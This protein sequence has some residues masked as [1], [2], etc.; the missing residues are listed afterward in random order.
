MLIATVTGAKAQDV[1]VPTVTIRQSEVSTSPIASH[2]RFTFWVSAQDDTALKYY[3]SAGGPLE[4]RARVS[5]NAAATIAQGGYRPW[6]AWPADFSTPIYLDVNC[7]YFYFEVRAVDAAGNYSTIASK[8]FVAPFPLAKAPVVPAFRQAAKTTEGGVTVQS[9]IADVDLDQDGTADIIEGDKATGIVSLR[10]NPA[11]DGVTLKTSTLSVSAGSL[12]AVAAGKLRSASNLPDVVISRSGSLVIYKNLGVN[13]TGDLE[14]SFSD[15][16]ELSTHYLS[17]ILVTDVTGDGVADIV[18][19]GSE[20]GENNY[21]VAVFANH[22][23]G[24]FADPHTYPVEAFIKSLAVGDMD[25]DGRPDLVVGEED[26]GVQVEVL[27][28]SADGTFS[29]GGL[30]Y[31]SYYG[32]RLGNVEVGD[33]NGDGVADIVFSSY[34][35]V[36]EGSNRYLLMAAECLFNNGHGTFESSLY[37]DADN[38]LAP[39]GYDPQT[40]RVTVAV[41]DTNFDGTKD[42]V[43]ASNVKTTGKVLHLKTIKDS[44]GTLL[45][46]VLASTAIF[47]NLAKPG[48]M[49]VGDLDNN[50][51][52]DLVFANESAVNPLNVMLNFTAGGLTAATKFTVAVTGD[53]NLLNGAVSGWDWVFSAVLTADLPNLSLKLQSKTETGA[54]TDV[55]GAVFVRQG[56]NGWKLVLTDMPVGLRSFRVVASATGFPDQITA[57]SPLVNVLP[58]AYSVD[59][60]IAD[61]TAV[62]AGKATVGPFNSTRMKNVEQGKTGIVAIK[63]TNLG[64]AEKIRFL[65]PRSNGSNKF[66]VQYATDPDFINNIS[67][68]ASLGVYE[69]AVLPKGGTATIYAKARAGSAT[70]SNELGAFTVLATSANDGV[71]TDSAT[72]TIKALLAKNV[73]F[74]TNNNDTGDGSLRA[75]LSNALLNPPKTGRP[76]PQVRFELAVADSNRP[77]IDVLSPLPPITSDSTFI[78]GNSEKEFAAFLIQTLPSA[79][80]GLRGKA[81]TQMRAAQAVTVEDGLQIYTSNTLIQGLWFGEF[82]RCIVISN[83]PQVTTLAKKNQVRGC[84]FA[85]FDNSG[86][87]LTNY[88]ASNIIGGTDVA[89][90]NVFQ[91]FTHTNVPFG[92]QGVLVSGTGCI[93]NRIEGNIIGTNSD[94]TDVNPTG[95][96]G[97][98]VAGILI[99]A[100]AQNTLVRK[101]VLSGNVGV[102]M[103]ASGLRIQGATTTGTKIQGN[104]IGVSIDGNTAIPNGAWG[105]AVD[106]PS[107]VVGGTSAGDANLISGNVRG[108]FITADYCTVQGNLIGTNSTGLLAIANDIGV[109]INEGVKKTVI[110]GAT[111]SA[112]NVISGNSYNAVRVSGQTGPVTTSE[113]SI[114]GNY[115]GLGSDGLT[116]VPNGSSGHPAIEILGAQKTTVTGNTIAYNSRDAVNISQATAVKNVVRQNWTYSNGGLG[117]NLV[118]AYDAPSGRTGN[119]AGDSDTGPNNLQ[120]APVLTSASVVK[121]GTLYYTD[122]RGTLNSNAGVGTVKNRYM[123]DFYTSDVAD[124]SGSG[125]GAVYLGSAEVVA[126]LP[127]NSTIFV[128]F[129]GDLTGKIITVTASRESSSSKP[130]PEE[131]SEFSNGVLS[132]KL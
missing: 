103:Y 6:Q 117:I 114:L 79:A 4:F 95:I 92:A 97:M 46:T 110:G 122:I 55:P 31:G 64:S 77:Y 53:T 23:D 87:C 27:L 70:T 51:K 128:R 102:E 10:R 113:N 94:G 126:D 99:E 80:V 63:L 88:A 18:A 62:T 76:A 5:R 47:T 59:V 121:V 112:R 35:T 120:N 115:I 107:T 16:L 67:I 14:F 30:N 12:Q 56:V 50:G 73:F 45:S 13:S 75:A 9:L 106:A 52:P 48:L 84:V 109:M 118:N 116:A 49:A 28:N 34:S 101:N 132:T 8:E 22:G 82:K 44:Q 65:A 43:L 119:D 1:T 26:Q 38:F 123:I 104:K 78:D 36:F 69:T 54:W 85:S 72:F 90:R 24:T 93:G 83:P 60:G 86:V 66:L 68:A 7:T 125:E 98:L 105:V 127:G 111:L 17:H 131:T 25:N 57:K 81:L 33:I 29:A 96:R 100:G 129:K 40:A 39:P 58:P 61:V 37:L 41:A 91:G 74:V 130:V 32:D 42:I 21:L 3:T 11:G 15:V 19:A 20:Y 71:H 2:K 108:V 89:H 124:D